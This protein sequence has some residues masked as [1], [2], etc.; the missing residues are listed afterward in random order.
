MVPITNSPYHTPAYTLFTGLM[1]NFKKQTPH[2]FGIAG[3]LQHASGPRYNSAEARA[4]YV[5]WMGTTRNLAGTHC[6][7]NLVTNKEVTGDTFTPAPLTADVVRMIGQ[8]AGATD[9]TPVPLQQPLLN[10]SP[11]HALDPLRGVTENTVALHR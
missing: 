4:D 3:F 9:L 11:L 1:P 8:L 2:P 6:C 7:W 10:P 5:I